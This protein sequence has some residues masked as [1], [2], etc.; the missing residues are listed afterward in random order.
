MFRKKKKNTMD[1]KLEKKMK[2]KT[3]VIHDNLD[4]RVQERKDRN[5]SFDVADLHERSRS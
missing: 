1:E 2:K 4:P 5:R 3:F